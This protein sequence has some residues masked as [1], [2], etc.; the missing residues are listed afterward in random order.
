MST[1]ASFEPISALGSP[2]PDRL[3]IELQRMITTGKL[4]PGD[5]FPSERAIADRLNV[6]RLCVRQALGD[7]EALGLI[8]FENARVRRVAMPKRRSIQNQTVAVLAQESRFD[9]QKIR[10]AGW[11]SYAEIMAAAYVQQKGY[12]ALTMNYRSLDALGVQELIDQCPAGVLA[13]HFCCEY[14]DGRALMHR[15]QDAGLPVVAMGSYSY[16]HGFDRVGSDH[17][18]GSAMLTRWLIERGCR[19]ILRLWRVPGR[20]EWIDQRNAGHESAMLDAGLTV[21]P[22]IRSRPATTA[23]SDEINFE[24][25][26]CSVL[27]HLYG[28]LQ[29]GQPVDAVMVATDMHVPPVAEAL[30]RL[31]KNPGR[32]VLI[33]GYDNTCA[34]DRRLLGARDLPAVTCDKRN[35]DLAALHADLLLERIAGDL[36]A[37]P[38]SRLTEP[39]LVV[40]SDDAKG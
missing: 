34:T 20:H 13:T 22:P 28:S 11:D 7:V 33:A 8:E 32:D 29:G 38:Q 40:V 10:S 36:P 1:L 14:E 15:L 24:E 19:N 3:A 25:T 21:T 4:K 26:V 17:A 16:L 12:H 2:S 23:E 39:E 31:G 18:A 9:P 27:G 35:A 6:S 30:R 5:R 37:A